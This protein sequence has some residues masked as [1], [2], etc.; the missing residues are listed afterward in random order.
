MPRSRASS[1]SPLPGSGFVADGREQLEAALRLPEIARR[2][3]EALKRRLDRWCSTWSPIGLI[4]VF[5][6]QQK[7]H[8]RI[9]RRYAPRPPGPGALFAGNPGG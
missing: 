9:L 4:R 8:R 6:R 5:F 3:Q 7:L 2:R 1:T